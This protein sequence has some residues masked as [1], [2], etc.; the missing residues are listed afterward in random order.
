MQKILPCLNALIPVRQTQPHTI[1]L[2]GDFSFTVDIAIFHWLILLALA[3]AILIFRI[4]VNRL[5]GILRSPSYCLLSP[6]TFW[7][8][9]TTHC[10]FD[11]E[12][13]DDTQLNF[14]AEENTTIPSTL[15]PSPPPPQEK[16]S[17]RKT[18]I[19]LITISNCLSCHLSIY[20]I[21]RSTEFWFA[22]Q[23]YMNNL[24]L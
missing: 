8:V 21:N 7:K 1:V 17:E 12:G 15:I 20:F 9:M 3:V 5:L 11:I 14:T 22:F 23:A 2:K 4:I 24:L 13:E 10:R 6:S 16:S 18:R 19:L